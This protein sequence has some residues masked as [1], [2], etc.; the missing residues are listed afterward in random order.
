MTTMTESSSSSPPHAVVV[1]PPCDFPPRRL[2]RRLPQFV[3]IP[4]LRIFVVG[5]AAI[6]IIVDDVVV[7]VVGRG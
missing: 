3:E 5:V 4:Y 1:E 6:A 2:R 7:S